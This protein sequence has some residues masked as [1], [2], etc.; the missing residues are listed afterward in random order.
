M[1]EITTYRTWV[2]RFGNP[3]AIDALE[4]DFA[5]KRCVV[6]LLPSFSDYIGNINVSTAIKEKNEKEKR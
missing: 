5:F 6:V 1:H 2:H 4:R 3:P